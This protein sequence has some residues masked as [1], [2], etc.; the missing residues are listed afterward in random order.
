MEGADVVRRLFDAVEAFGGN[1][2]GGLLQ[3]LGGH[4]QGGPHVRTV[5]PPDI[6]EDGAVAALAD[7]TH[8]QVF[9]GNEGK[10]FKHGSFDDFFVDVDAGGD[11]AHKP[12]HCV[13]GEETL[14]K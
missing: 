12:E 10:I 14:R 4:A 11:V 5:E 2:A 8:E 7:R 6:L 9:R 1:V 13:T 3:I